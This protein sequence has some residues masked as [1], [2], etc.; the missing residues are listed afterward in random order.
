M[1]HDLLKPA[2]EYWVV[3]ITKKGKRVVIKED[4]RQDQAQR[5]VEEMK[6]ATWYRP[7]SVRVA[8]MLLQEVKQFSVHRPSPIGW[9]K[10]FRAAVMS[11]DPE[12]LSLNFFIPPIRRKIS[13]GRFLISVGQIEGYWYYKS[14]CDL[15]HLEVLEVRKVLKKIEQA[16]GAT[17]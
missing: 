16:M 2:R 3:G 5:I 9:I 4:V 1:K 6:T 13:A 14:I 7:G 11:K 15:N 12:M 17:S 10:L 8:K